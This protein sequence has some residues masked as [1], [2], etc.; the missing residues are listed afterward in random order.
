M[1][2]AHGWET[3]TPE[4]VVKRY[5]N[6]GTVSARNELF[7]CEI[8]G[9]YVTLANGDKRTAHFKHS[10]K[11]RNKDCEERARNMKRVD[12]LDSQTPPIIEPPIK[13]C[14]T[15]QDFYFERDGV[16]LSTEKCIVEMEG[17]LFSAIS[18]KRLPLDSD[19]RLN[20]KYYLLTSKG[21]KHFP[22]DVSVNFLVR[23]NINHNTWRLY[24]VEAA[25]L[26][27][28]AA[29]FFLH[30]HYRLTDNPIAIRVIY[31]LVTVEP[32]RVCHDAQALYVYV[33]G[34][35]K[36][37]CF[38]HAYYKKLSSDRNGKL[39]KVFCNDKQQVTMFA[40]RSRPLKYLYLRRGLPTV[41][42][43]TP[44]VEVKDVPGNDIING[45][46]NHLPQDRL[47]M[48]RA[49]FDGYVEINREGFVENRI[50]IKAGEWFDVTAL[51]YGV[52]IK[53]YAGLDCI[54]S[55]RF[56]RAASDHAS[57]DEELY[58]KLERGRGRPIKISHAWGS[59]ADRLK[60]YP[61]VRGWLRKTIC[62]G[63]APEEAYIL[64]RRFV[65]NG[66]LM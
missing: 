58:L 22:G 42:I 61:K 27:Q 48:L 5:P 36:V 34:N 17:A 45:M 12:W 66:G 4:E 40:G 59:L 43:K 7:F 35:A 33:G 62:A 46:L 44:T 25:A 41:E 63:V 32:Y 16:R 39:I 13:I 65:L 14:V 10:S 30:Y 20:K 21:F 9:Q 31:P 6:I 56:E 51:D 19:V 11:E 28:E 60:D 55:I 1:W 29:N 47:L 26:T 37:A 3:I 54:R 57:A 15:Q 64:F 24:E 52:E 2:T 23:K 49:E 38:P 8:C 53:I 50:E 18:G